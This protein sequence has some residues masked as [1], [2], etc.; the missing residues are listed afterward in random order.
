MAAL[1]DAV[2]EPKLFV[3]VFVVAK[4]ISTIDSAIQ[5]VIDASRNLNAVTPRQRA[6]PERRGEALFNRD[7][8]LAQ[9]RE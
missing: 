6:I 5:D 1:G 7:Q 4:D 3:P 8:A 2:E 9:F